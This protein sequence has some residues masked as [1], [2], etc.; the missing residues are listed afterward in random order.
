METYGGSRCIDPRFLTSVLVA[1]SDQLYAPAVLTPWQPP[2]PIR[3]DAEWTAEAAW[4]T[5]R[6]EN[7]RTPTFGSRARSQ[8]LHRLRYR[9]R[10]EK[11]TCPCV[12][13]A[14][15]SSPGSVGMRRRRE[16]GNGTTE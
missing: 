4:T 9:G 13:S 16:G 5:W 15:D 12:E 11:C 10:T 14:P 2:V 3:H 1:M 8:L 7:S 6:N